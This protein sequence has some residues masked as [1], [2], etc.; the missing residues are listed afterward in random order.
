MQRAEIDITTPDGTMSAYAVHPDGEEKRPAILF[1]MDGLGYRDALKA[2]ADRL[3][4]AGYHVLLPDLY[5]RVA[6]HLSFDPAV[7][8]QPE[9]M[10]DMRKMIGS[11]TAD[12]VMSD[13][14]MCLAL[15]GSRPDVDPT[16]IGAVGYCMGGRNALILA[17]RQPDRIRAAAAIHPG[18]LVT[19]EPTSPHLGVAGVK[20]RLYIAQAK[21]DM[22]FTV[23]HAATL[24]AALKAA[25]VRYQLEPY[26]ARHGWAVN[27]TPVHD[28]A[29]A[30]RHWKAILG[31]FADELG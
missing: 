29:E 27:D 16:R 5:Y 15:L 20:A 28:P 21:D 1:F 30:E 19:A 13:A 6:R 17:S 14:S 7:L 24:E 11:L 2:M 8:T 3:A 18:G 31:L 12:M 23:E 9:K 10:A 22:F 25:G 26:A 4:T